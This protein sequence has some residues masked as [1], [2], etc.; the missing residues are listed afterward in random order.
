MLRCDRL[1]SVRLY[2]DGAI[3][4]VGCFGIEKRAEVGVDYGPEQRRA[5]DEHK[6]VSGFRSTCHRGQGV[7][8]DST[9]TATSWRR[10]IKVRTNR[11]TLTWIVWKSAKRLRSNW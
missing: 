6:G 2:K 1:S 5:Q 9:G 7:L 4:V 10:L 8:S 3:T 11:M